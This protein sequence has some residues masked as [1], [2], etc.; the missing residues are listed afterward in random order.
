MNAVLAPL[1]TPAAP[2]AAEAVVFDMDGLL[3]DTE[4]LAREALQLAGRELGLPLPDEV[5]R[6]MIGV[7]VDGTTRLLLAHF[8]NEA[9][10]E[11]LLGA[12]SRHLHA[13]IGAG[14]LR[15]KPGV[16][17][18]LDALDRTG[19]PRAVATSSARA[20]ALHHL[21]AAGLFDRFNA[22][23]TRDD[24]A[25]GKP[26]PDLYLAAAERL[27]LAPAHCLAL[28]DSYNGVRAACAAGMPVVMVPDLLPATDE[29]RRV[30]HA[31]VDSLYDV[32]TLIEKS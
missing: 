16:G 30:C 7:P 20:K 24:V 23:L 12:A 5:S 22:V 25:R 21:N 28:E 26:H 10:I 9:P 3:L 11:R 17:A 15:V 18:L 27:G 19:L 31:V 2:L 4:V 8:G 6:Q 13:L 29:M 1:V 14:N 32:L